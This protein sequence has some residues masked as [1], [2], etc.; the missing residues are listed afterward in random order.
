MLVKSELDK[1]DVGYKNI[2]LGEIQLTNELSLVHREALN[3]AFKESGL[4]ILETKKSILIESIKNVI[5]KM[6]HYSEEL[7]SENYSSIISKKLNHNYTYLA[8]V[9]S[10]SENLTI[11]HFI[12]SHKI[13]KVKE[14][15]LYNEL[16]IT[17]IS[18]KMH[19]SSVAHLSNQ[20]KKV[21][22]KTPTY[23]K[24]KTHRRKYLENVN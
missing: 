7:P 6:I 16:N 21:T 10:E 23:F 11:E 2:D 24:N 20:F 3:A 18:Y 17:E 5:I 9:F 22:G 4:E 15:L 12:I 8:N 19:Y 1:L 14:L 13:E